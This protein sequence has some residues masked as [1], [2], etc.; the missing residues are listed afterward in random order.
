MFRITVICNSNTNINL[1]INVQDLGCTAETSKFND[2]Y[3]T[4]SGLFSCSYYINDAPLFA[5]CVLCGI[6]SFVKVLETWNLSAEDYISPGSI[7][8]SGKSHTAI[9]C[10]V[11]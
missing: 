1:D 7:V 6:V 10:P 2:F 3:I 5:S 9:P 8:S 4:P 11:R